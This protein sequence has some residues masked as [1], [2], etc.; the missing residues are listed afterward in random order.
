MTEESAGDRVHRASPIARWLRHLPEGVM[1][2]LGVMLAFLM[3]EYREE[4]EREQL[5]VAAMQRVNLEVASNFSEVIAIHAITRERLAKL[6]SLESAAD[7]TLPFTRLI[8]R[9]TGYPFLQ[10][11]RSAW[12]GMQ[13]GAYLDK[14]APDY[15]ADVFVIYDWNEVLKSL[16]D[17]VTDL[18]FGADVH[19]PERTATVWAI[20]RSIMEQQA[21][22]GGEAIQAYCQFMQAWAPELYAQRQDQ[23]Q[24]VMDQ[25]M[26]SF[27]DA[28]S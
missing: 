6:E 24:E 28:C 26:P 7:D 20:S 4:R 5:A 17:R 9:F 22:W 1:V 13:L 16:D 23:H 8:P 27:R 19:E 11:D 21:I 14:V 3:E 15:L 12:S 25:E 2:L 18:V 10:T